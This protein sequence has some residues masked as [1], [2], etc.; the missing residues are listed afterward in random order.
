[1][2]SAKRRQ[3]APGGPA[4]AGPAAG[5]GLGAAV[6]RLTP[7]ARAIPRTAFQHAIRL[8]HPY[9]GGEHLLLALAGADDPAAAVLRQHGVTPGRVEEEVLTLW[10][11]GLFGDL[12]R[13]ALAAIG[14][15]VD[16]VRVR[17]TGG[18][19]ADTLRR[20]GQRARRGKHAGGWRDPW[21]D[22]RPRRIGPGM[23]INGVYLPHSLDFGQCLR[24][25][26]LEEQ[27][28][29]DTGIGVVHLAL[30]VL[31]VTDGLVPPVLAAIGVSPQALR[32]A[33]AAI[34][35]I[36]NGEAPDEGTTWT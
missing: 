36:A 11:D 7:E 22:P 19:D 2:D 4:P 6:R 12:D 10:A 1:M 35:A 34:A 33:L 8:G 31:S 20:A 24:Y 25:A 9:V 26:H 16:A 23:H 27:G 30:G 3:P 5:Q 14:V 18:F 17:V 21:W 29:R 13:S 32:S 28:R 15:D